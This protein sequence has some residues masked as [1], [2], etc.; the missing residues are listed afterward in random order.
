MDRVAGA[1]GWCAFDYNTHVEF[2]S[3][4]RICYHGVM[5]I[6][7]LPKHAAYVYASQVDPAQR[8][9]LYPATIW[10]KGDRSVGGFEPTYIFS[11]CD[12]VEVFVGEDRLGRFQPCREEFPH[13]PHP[14]FKATG[15][16]SFW[17]Q[18]QHLD[19]RVV[20]YIGGKAVAEHCIAADGL[21]HALELRADDDQ[22]WADGADMTRVVFRVVD[23]CGSRLPYTQSVIALEVDGPA[24][25][26]GENPFPLMGGQAAVYVK[27]RHEPG[28]VTI[29]ATTPRLPTA[30]IKIM[31]IQPG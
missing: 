26:I 22:L 30:E 12:E 29:R 18:K 15:F 1:I 31:T 11:N 10:A 16:K 20:G 13:L 28:T 8:I 3:G 23:R 24:E 4:D 19:L 2:G 14:P 27:A 25:L 17:G 9:V 6:F 5:D 7:R 21:P